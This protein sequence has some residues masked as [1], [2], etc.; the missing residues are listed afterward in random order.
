[1]PE[2]IRTLSLDLTCYLNSDWREAGPSQLHGLL[3]SRLS[4]WG[5]HWTGEVSEVVSGLVRGNRHPMVSCLSAPLP[6][7]II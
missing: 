7:P 5:L 3:R 1:M 6:D 2:S 4:R